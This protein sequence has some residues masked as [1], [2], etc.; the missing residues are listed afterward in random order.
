MRGRDK[1]GDDDMNDPRP[2]PANAHVRAWDLPTRL[3]HWALVL[4]V[5]GAYVTRKYS[6][7]LT[8]HIWNGYAILVLVVFRV[9]WGFVGSST[10][11]FASFLYWPWTSARYG[12]DFLLRRPRFFLSHNPLGSLAA[13]AML[14]LIALQGLLGLFSYDDHD[15]ID[16]GPLSGRAAAATV[17]AATAWHLWLFYLLLTVIGVHILANILYLVWKRENLITP[18]FTGRKP[19]KPFED[20]PEAEIAPAWRAIACL[21]LAVTIVF[22]GIM[23]AGG[24]PF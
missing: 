12:L 24:K 3:F 9:L 10:S 4:L 19:A 23:L 7:T 5:I 20:Q 22:G 1:V 6:D 11:R 21:L 14:G 2:E 16:G 18:M 17:A 15:S 13:F 8:W